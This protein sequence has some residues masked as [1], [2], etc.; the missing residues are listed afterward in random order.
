MEINRTYTF[1]G[2]IDAVW[3]LLMDTSAIAACV[4]GCR[5]LRPLGDD[6][7]RAELSVPVAAI[8]GQFEATISLEGK[9]PPRAYTLIVQA[10]G[11]PGFVRGQ[12]VVTLA[13]EQ[14]RTEVHVLTVADVGGAI[15]RVGQRLLEGAGRMMMDRFFECLKNKLADAQ[16]S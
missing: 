8:S 3:A 14:D 12:A 2:P 13:P 1:D 11:R 9:I 5:E 15:A 7:F 4:P 10:T 16:G 6:R